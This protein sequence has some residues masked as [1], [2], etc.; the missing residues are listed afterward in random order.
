MGTDG[1]SSSLI[2]LPATPLAKSVPMGRLLSEI[3]AGSLAL[4][5]QE[6]VFSIGVYHWC[7]P[8]Y[9]QIL[10]WANALGFEPE[11]VIRRLVDP[12]KWGGMDALPFD[13]YGKEELFDSLQGK[14][15]QFC[16]GKIIHISWDFELLPLTTFQWVEGL[17]IEYFKIVS[18]RNA[19]A[20][21]LEFAPTLP[22]LRVLSVD[23]LE[24]RNL[25]LSGVPILEF[26]SCSRNLLANLDLSSV[27]ALREL[28]CSYNCLREIDLSN[29]WTL[30]SIDCRGNLLVRLNI[31]N[32]KMRDV[33]DPICD[34]WV[35]TENGECGNDQWGLLPQSVFERLQTDKAQPEAAYQN[36]EEYLRSL[37]YRIVKRRDD[38]DAVG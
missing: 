28:I 16:N 2:P 38:R 5:R 27:P 10:L 13:P 25:D 17:E 26:L 11:E 1:D 18:H 29:S 12:S 14:E 37:G 22:K 36:Y 35:L 33:Y 3:V 32:T 7:G 21:I 8:D 24:I 9:R 19:P 15:T 23:G 31:E 30:R 20:S 4:A 34:G 6:A